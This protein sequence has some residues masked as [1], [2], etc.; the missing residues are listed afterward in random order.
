MRCVA[1]F[2][3]AGHI[4]LQPPSTCHVLQVWRAASLFLQKT[5][6]PS[7]QIGLFDTSCTAVV[8]S[9]CVALQQEL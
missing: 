6:V 1:Y 9:G 2:E 7:T 5:A 8:P 4:L 3:T